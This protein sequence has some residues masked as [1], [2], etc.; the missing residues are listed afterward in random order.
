MRSAV[1][2]KPSAATGSPVPQAMLDELE[3]V[4]ATVRKPIDFPDAPAEVDLWMP[5]E[6]VQQVDTI[7]RAHGFHPFAAP[8]HGD[9]RF[10]LG[11]HSN[12]WIKLDFKLSP[13]GRK[14]SSRLQAVARRLPAAT[15]RL[16]TV[17][18]FVGP[19]GAGKGTVIE[20][21]E[22]SIPVAVDVMILGRGSA[23]YQQKR[24]RILAS[25][26]AARDMQIPRWRRILEPFFVGRMMFRRSGQLLRVYA[27]AWRG[28]I[29][30]CD[31]HPLEALATNP[32]RTWLAR[33]LE[34]FVVNR[35]LPWPDR[36]VLLDAPGEVM[37]A[38]KGEHSAE[39]L[40]TWRQGYAAALSGPH[41]R[42]VVVRTDGAAQDSIAAASSV[43]W[44][45]LAER[46]RWPGLAR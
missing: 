29:V 27:A 12:S 41:R 15:R 23:R 37:F 45:A 26:P 19:D 20:A 18:A 30:L 32:R 44:E 11:F 38:R 25:T 1:S 40:E 16:G 46:R 4:G 43:V 36:V 13:G 22:Q 34:R 33:E 28:R 24:A 10:Y 39:I 31:R 3:Q 17:V 8:G 21:V 35:L 9:H 14:R 6:A 7:T 5:P 2:P 42:T